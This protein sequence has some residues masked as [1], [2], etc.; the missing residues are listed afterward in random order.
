MKKEWTFER[1]V[2]DAAALLRLGQD[3]SYLDSADPNLPWAD[4]CKV[5][6][7]GCVRNG[8]C[9][10]CWFHAEHASG[11]EFV[12][13]IDIEPASM[14]GTPRFGIDVA[15]CRGVMGKLPEN[16]AKAFAAY[17]TD[18]ANKVEARAAEFSA[19]ATNQQQIAAQLREAVGV[20]PDDW[21]A[22]RSGMRPVLNLDTREEIK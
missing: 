7:T 6:P 8:M 12:W 10:T 3:V 18:C 5:D 17:L 11:I 14:D 13:S 15:K 16:A 9:V 21:A 20:P 19:A 4:V 22:Q 1:C 2:A